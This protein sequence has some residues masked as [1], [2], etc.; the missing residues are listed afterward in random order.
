[1]F[2]QLTL[3]VSLLLTFVIAFNSKVFAQPILPDLAS[4]T[5]NGINVITW[6][7]QFEGVKSIAIL[8]SSDSN[9]NF[10]T[11]GY[12]KD[13]KKGIQYYLDGH[14]KAGVNWYKLNIVFGSSLAWT[15]NRLKIKV[16]STQIAKGKVMPSNDS[17]QYLASKFRTKTIDLSEDVLKPTVGGT[18]AA[19]LVVTNTSV[20]S[21]VKIDSSNIKPR[22]TIKIPDIGQVDAYSYIKSQY[23]FTNPFTGHVNVEIADVAKYK[24]SIDFFDAANVKVLDIPKISE[25]SIIIDKRNFQRTGMYRFELMKDRVK[26][27]TGYVTIY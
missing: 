21:N 4:V 8:R 22:P 23:V 10:I 11:I 17:L 2:N 20:V 5:Q 18:P 3:R 9:F 7:C 24:Y 19:N 14:P 13:I 25:S 27:E 1:M 12:V 6:N 15:S 26:I 16:D